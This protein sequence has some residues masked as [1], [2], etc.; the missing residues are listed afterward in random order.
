MLKKCM[1]IA[2]IATV[3]MAASATA[4]SAATHTVK[5]KTVKSCSGW[6]A[7][8]FAGGKIKGKYTGTF[9]TCTSVGKLV[10]P[11]TVQRMKCAKGG[12]EFTTLATTGAAND[13]KGTWK[14]SKGT[15]AY[16]GIT[17]AGSYTGQISTGYF[18]YTGK[19]KY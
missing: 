1:T 10:V 19:A 16:K 11:D 4:A 5:M 3:A 7:C 15:G 18:T 17:G 8:G 6:P 14:I 12:F 9:G 13:V 2:A